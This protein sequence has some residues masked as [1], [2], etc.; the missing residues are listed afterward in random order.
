[1]EFE[2][3]FEELCEE[4]FWDIVNFESTHLMKNNKEYKKCSN[5]CTEIVGK[6]PNLQ[7]VLEDDI[8]MALSKEEVTN[9]IE[10]INNC[11][12]RSLMEKKQIIVSSCRN[13]YFVLK[14]IGLLKDTN[15]D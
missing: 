6:Y 15:S 5:K 13:S 11:R 14:K 4:R 8:P 2:K 1:M 10:Y 3:V 9:L 7:R 12:E